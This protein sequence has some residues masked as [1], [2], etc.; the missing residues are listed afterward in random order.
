[1]DWDIFDAE[2]TY[3]PEEGYAGKVSFALHGQRSG[4]E[5][6]LLSK[7]GLEWSYSLNFARESGSEEE[8]EATEQRLEEDDELFDALIEAAKSKL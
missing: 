4:Y 1:M 7:K 5:I 8:I 6:T 2:M 3:S